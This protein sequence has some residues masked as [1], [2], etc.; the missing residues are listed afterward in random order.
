[1]DEGNDEGISDK[2]TDDD[3]NQLEDEA[4][5]AISAQDGGRD[6]DEDEYLR[7]CF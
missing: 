7:N 4:E 6:A 5:A 3:F 1:M 2:L